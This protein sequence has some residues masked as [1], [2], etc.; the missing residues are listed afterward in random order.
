MSPTKDS[1]RANSPQNACSVHS[2]RDTFLQF[3]AYTM[4]GN[5]HYGGVMCKVLGQ[6]E[7]Q[8]LH[9]QVL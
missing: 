5:H 8:D 4:H 6:R 9:S 2:L 1:A 7:P 3:Q